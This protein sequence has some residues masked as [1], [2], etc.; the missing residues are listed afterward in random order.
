MFL[1]ICLFIPSTWWSVWLICLIVFRRYWFK[2]F[3]IELRQQLAPRVT[4]DRSLLVVFLSGQD[5]SPPFIQCILLGFEL[6]LLLLQGPGY[7]NELSLEAFLV[8]GFLWDNK[9]LVIEAD[10]LFG[11]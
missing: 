3:I 2:D 7:S 8:E 11:F 6:S 1:L 5:L 10:L 4:F 9:V